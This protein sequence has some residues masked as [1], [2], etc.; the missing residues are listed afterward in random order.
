MHIHKHTHTN[1]H[2]KPGNTHR[3]THAGTHRHMHK[4]RCISPTHA[5]CAKS[6]CTGMQPWAHIHTSTCAHTYTQ[7]CTHAS[8]KNT[9]SLPKWTDAAPLEAQRHSRCSLANQMGCH[10]IVHEYFTKWLHS[11]PPT[12]AATLGQ[13]IRSLKYMDGHPLTVCSNHSS[14]RLCTFFQGCF[15]D[16][17]RLYV[18][19][20]KHCNI[21]SFTWSGSKLTTTNND[22]TNE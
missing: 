2:H 8:S 17:L 18:L 9:R 7:A 3:Q 5:F 1:T 15:Y 21:W 11:R 16:H 12:T 13:I 14:R 10:L 20:C 22:I 6:T 4:K 19:K